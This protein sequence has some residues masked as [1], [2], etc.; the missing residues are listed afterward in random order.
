M[1]KCC[2]KCVF[3]TGYHAAF[4]VT[5]DEMFKR[6]VAQVHDLILM[7]EDRTGIFKQGAD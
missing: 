2:E 3:G 1:T 7:I 5:L 4:C 6:M